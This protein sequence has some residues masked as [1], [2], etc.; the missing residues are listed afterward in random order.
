MVEF[1]YLITNT[2]TLMY[3]LII[4]KSYLII[5]IFLAKVFNMSQVTEIVSMSLLGFCQVVQRQIW[6]IYAIKV[7]TF[8]CW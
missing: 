8:F 4:E 5:G 7:N 2:Y 1:W 6:Q 3:F